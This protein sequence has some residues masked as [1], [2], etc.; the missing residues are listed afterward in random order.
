[1]NARDRGFKISP[2]YSLL[3]VSG[4]AAL[5]GCT[6]AALDD[7]EAPVE[8]VGQ[9]ATTTPNGLTAINGLS[10][11]N[12]LTAI[13]GLM[14]I[15]GLSAMN[16]L[17]TVN[18]LADANTSAGA[19]GLMSTAAGRTTVSYLA[20]CALPP[21]RNLVKKDKSGVSYTFPGALGFAPA[22]ESGACDADCQANMSACMMAHINTSG[23]HIALWLDSD[24]PSIGWGESAAYPFQEGSFFG[25]LFTSPP[26]AYYCDGRDFDRGVVAGRIGANQTGAPYANYAGTSG[27][28]CSSVCVAADSPHESDG[29]KTCAGYKHPV[30]V[31][32]DFDPKTPYKMC[33]INTGTCAD[34]ADWSTVDKGNVIAWHYNGGSNQQWNI[35][36]VG[37]GYYKIVNV[38]SGKCLD[39]VG[40]SL[41]PEANVQ[42]YTCHGGDNQQWKIV[43]KGPGY[44]Q[45][46]AKLTAALS[47]ADRMCLDVTGNTSLDGANIQQ[48]GCDM[49][50]GI[51]RQFQISIAQ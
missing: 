40:Q 44:Y 20:R 25:N 15:N 34:V 4:L 37:S 35:I 36:N 38:N 30:T 10:A 6:A 39:V 27:A 17:M 2:S 12:G 29:F 45:I 16:G 28:L 8:S 43:P 42:Q 51:A 21:G 5:T 26:K 47:P 23:Q 49:Y 3:L 7:G 24:N 46:V 22:W 1:M 13:N 18:G 41:L 50:Q 31:W 32:R 14:S 33:N 19:N 48:F 9:E 11:I